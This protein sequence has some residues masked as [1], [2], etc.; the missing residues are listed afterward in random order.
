MSIV[1]QYRTLAHPSPKRKSFHALLHFIFN[2]GTNLITALDFDDIHCS[3]SLDQKVNL[4]A[5]RSAIAT[6]AH[7]SVGRSRLD[8]GISDSKK[9]H[10]FH[11]IV[12]DQVLELKPHYRIPGR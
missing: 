7:I 8:C 9:A 5:C 12:D 3:R 6:L 2:L 11:R 4:A 10:D 1:H